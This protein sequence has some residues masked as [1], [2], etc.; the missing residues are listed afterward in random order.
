MRKLFKVLG[1]TLAVICVAL[2]GVYWSGYGGQLAMSLFVATSGPPGA[3]A[4]EDAVPAPDYADES[5]WAALPGKVDPSASQTGIDLE[6]RALQYSIT[7][8]LCWIA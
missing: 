8:R 5:N 2:L 1:I 4:P 3:F 6:P 7:S